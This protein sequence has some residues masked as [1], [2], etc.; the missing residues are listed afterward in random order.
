MGRPR[1]YLVSEDK[2]GQWELRQVCAAR[3]VLT[4]NAQDRVYQ[5]EDHRQGCQ[6]V[7][8]GQAAG[9][10][11]DPE[12]HGDDGDGQDGEDNADGD[13]GH[14]LRLCLDLG[15]GVFYPLGHVCATVWWSSV[16]ARNQ[17]QKGGCSDR[18]SR[19]FPRG[20]SGLAQ[21]ST[22][23]NG[24]SARTAMIGV[25]DRQTCFHIRSPSRRT[26]TQMSPARRPFQV[27]R[28]S[29]PAVLRTTTSAASVSGFPSMPWMD[30]EWNNPS[31]RTH[32]GPSPV[33]TVSDGL[34]PGIPMEREGDPTATRRRDCAGQGRNTPPRRGKAWNEAC[35]AQ[36]RHTLQLQEKGVAGPA[37]LP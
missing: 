19:K 16:P 28:L 18:Q 3:C 22:Q 34:E 32:A 31:R 4:K 1:P 36:E 6:V 17:R 35:S 30:R 2:S 11:A 20:R 10:L 15:R 14:I 21:R 37:E 8:G 26:Y 29:V 24:R 7:V 23:R 5:G 13:D 12:S 25:E 27:T 9:L 33:R